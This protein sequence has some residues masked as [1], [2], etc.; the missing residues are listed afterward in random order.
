MLPVRNEPQCDLIE[1]EF[2]VVQCLPDDRA[3]NNEDGNY[4]Y[5][6][7][8]NVLY[9]SPRL[10]AARANTLTSVPLLSSSRVAR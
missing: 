3:E 2:A 4:T 10:W 1:R 7:A 5:A 8:T 9:G 6:I